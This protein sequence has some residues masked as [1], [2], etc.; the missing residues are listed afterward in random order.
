MIDCRSL[1]KVE[2]HCHLLGVI[3]PRILREIEQQG[4]RILVDPNTLDPIHP[5]HGLETFRR[6]ID[7]LKPYQAGT[8]EIMR[9]ILEAHIEDLR[10]QHVRYTEIM[11]SPTM[12]PREKS[13]MLD[14]VVRWREWASGMERGQ[15]QVEFLFVIPRTLTPELLE[16]DTARFIELRRANLIAG[17]ALVGI[18]SCESIRRFGSSF[19]RL[20]GEGL[21]VE[22]HAGEHTEPEWIWDALEHGQPD[23]LGHAISAFQDARLLDHIRS[24]GIHIEF[25]PTSNVRTGAIATIDQHPIG[26]AKELGLSFSLNT[27]DPGTFDCSLTDEYQQVA[28]SFGFSEDDLTELYEKSL[29]AR[30]ARSLRY[31][32]NS[33][34]Q[35]KTPRGDA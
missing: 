12:F 11:L 19:S 9:P 31:M 29:A 33:G 34:M 17:V 14:A 3:S 8:P 22:I 2:L 27:D 21:G 26:M 28:A 4:R 25:C 7:L 30:F 16:H 18:E 20:R 6:W 32:P 35:P 10:S 23:R 1:P 13:A 5:V 24:A 15:I